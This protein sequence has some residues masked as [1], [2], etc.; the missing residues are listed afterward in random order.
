MNE[1]Y[2]Y[3]LQKDHPRANKDGYVYQHILVA[4]SILGRPLTCNEV[5]HHIDGNRKNNSPDNLMI[6]ASDSDH[7]SFHKGCICVNNNGTYERIDKPL[8]EDAFCKL[9]GNPVYKRGNI[10]KVCLGKKQRVAVRPSRNELKELIKNNSFCEI[11]KQFH[12]SDNAIRK[13]C[14]YYSLPSTATE[15]KQITFDAWKNI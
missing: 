14:K 2:E 10:C 9:C 8:H 13:W 3:V 6:F 1:T 15:I 4:E 12:V 5:V 11:A 7:V